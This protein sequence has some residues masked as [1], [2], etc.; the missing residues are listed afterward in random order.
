[1]GTNAG[2]AESGGA[3]GVPLTGGPN[4]QPAAG[5]TA[6]A[7]RP[8]A[9]LVAETGLAIG[10]ASAR[11]PVRRVPAGGAVGLS[12]VMA[13]THE[14]RPTV[15]VAR[16]SGVTLRVSGGTQGFGRAAASAGR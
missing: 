9:S 15:G 6:V 14:C 7:V 10:P 12:A 16:A 2:H 4:R 11:R 8:A 5:R 3:G 1:M 13:L